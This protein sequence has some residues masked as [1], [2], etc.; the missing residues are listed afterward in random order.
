M[1]YYDKY[2]EDAGRVKKIIKYLQDN[3]VNTP[4]GGNLSASRFL[5]MGLVFGFHG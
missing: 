1:A 2:P 4:S 5:A 3:N